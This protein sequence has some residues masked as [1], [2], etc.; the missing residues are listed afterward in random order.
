MGSAM[1]ENPNG[2]LSDDD[3]ETVGG[4]S[5]GRVGDADGTDGTDADGTDGTDADGT[6]S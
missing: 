6:D 5:G 1:T 3:M 2:P 4:G